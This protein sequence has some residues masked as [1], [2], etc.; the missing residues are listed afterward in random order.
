[1]TNVAAD[2][3]TQRSAA[4]RAVHDCAPRSDWAE[5]RHNVCRDPSNWGGA[6]VVAGTRIP[7]FMIQDMYAE[8]QSLPE[9]LACYPSLDLAD[10]LSALAYAEHASGLVAEDRARHEMAVERAFQ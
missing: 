2:W 4:W 3:G 10:L 1:M 6:A 9:V 7:V 8:T 5:E